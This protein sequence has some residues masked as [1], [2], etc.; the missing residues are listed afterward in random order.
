[1][2]DAN[3]YTITGAVLDQFAD[4]PDPRLKTLVQAHCG[5]Q[6]SLH[7]DAMKNTPDMSAF[8]RSS[9]TQKPWITSRE[10][11]WIVVG[12]LTGRCIT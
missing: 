12:V 10:V 6:S 9:G 3:E 11:T 7:T 2:R 5:M 1:M 8:M 4:T